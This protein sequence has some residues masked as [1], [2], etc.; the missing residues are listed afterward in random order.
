MLCY[1]NGVDHWN[2]L[3]NISMDGTVR[4]SAQKIAKFF[5]SAEFFELNANLTFKKIP[6]PVNGKYS[7]YFQFN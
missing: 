4:S 1:M 3:Q 2:Y 7:T 5:L 6:S